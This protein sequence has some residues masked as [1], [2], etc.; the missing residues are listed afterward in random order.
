MLWRDSRQ[1]VGVNMKDVFVHPLALVETDDIGEGTRVWAFAHVLKGARVG[2]NCNIGD[3]SFLE[4]GVVIGDNVTI[5]NGSMIW[6]GITIED[7]VFVGPQV[8]FSNDRH[9]RSP[10]LPQA[11]QRYADKSWLDTTLV[12]RGAS[13]GAGA[14]LV[15]GLVIGEF[16]MIGAGAVVT[17]DV[18]PYALVMG[19]PAKRK[20]WVCQCGE[21]LEV[22][23]RRATCPSCSLSYFLDE[24]GLKPA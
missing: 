22:L 6:E 20:G 13:I 10:R 17:E 11:S 14:V 2:A 12:K 18:A 19:N 23:E 3:H 24:L 15:P 8:Y 4:A 16:A 9:P 1:E 7:G 21:R 5:K